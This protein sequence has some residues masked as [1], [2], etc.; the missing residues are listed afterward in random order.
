MRLLDYLLEKH[1]IESHN[2]SGVDQYCVVDGTGPDGIWTNMH[3]LDGCFDGVGSANNKSDNV[4]SDKD[5]ELCERIEWDDTMDEH[6][7]FGSLMGSRHIRVRGQRVA[8]GEA[9]EILKD[10]YVGDLKSILC[11]EWMH[12]NG[13]LGSE[14]VS[15]DCLEFND[16]LRAGFY[17]AKKFPY[18]DM[19]IAIST[20]SSQEVWESEAAKNPCYGQDEDWVCD[21]LDCV[22]QVE[23]GAVSIVSGEEAQRIYQQ[24]ITDCEEKDT[25]I[26][27]NFNVPDEYLEVINGNTPYNPFLLERIAKTQPEYE[28][29][30]DTDL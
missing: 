20:F 7:A 24:Y 29:Y 30:G 12:I 6:R 21:S 3:Q 10:Y 16:L 19:M 11:S 17:I 5:V 9:F 27:T 23:Y 25:S 18:V 2:V 13:V 26:Y 4:L 15:S 28:I 14:G 8:Y 1:F 22:I